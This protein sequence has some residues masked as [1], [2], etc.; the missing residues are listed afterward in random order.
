MKLIVNQFF[1]K[2]EENKKISIFEKKWINIMANI[3]AFNEMKETFSLNKTEITEYGF[4]SL[5]L[6]VDGL[7]YSKLETAKEYIE[8][9]FGCM[10]VFNKARRS[11]LVNAEFIFNSPTG[12]KFEPIKIKPWEIYLGNDY[13]GNPIVVDMVTW[14]HVLITGGTRSGKS[15]LMDCI[16]TSLIVNS[17]KENLQLYLIQVAKSDLILYRSC[18][19][20]RAFADTEEKT[21][22]VLNRVNEIM[23]ERTKLITPYREEAEAD[24]YQDYNKKNRLQEMSSIFV[25]FDEMSSLFEDGNKD[26]V[27]LIRRIAQYGAGLGVFLI[28]SLQRPTKDNLDSFV[29]SQSTLKISFRQN[30]SKSSEVA[31][32]DAQIAL[33]LEQREFVYYTKSY[34]YGLVPLVD[35]KKIKG[36]ITPF[37]EK[38]HRDL[39]QD[40]EKAIKVKYKEKVVPFE[41]VHLITKSKEDILA[42]NIAKIPGYVPYIGEGKVK[43]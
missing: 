35:N 29:K 13:A 43:A 10:C 24:N 17:T 37:K 26:I 9:A 39:F 22:Q 19:Q 34:N 42:E 38:N 25:V 23:D 11:N 6:I 8:D 28:C 15:K 30:N 41:P 7:T 33:G 5:I 2:L 18:K 3:K 32:D 31:L 14:P 16:L 4:K 21:L 1:N 36:Y 12:L 27:T 20:A 40:L